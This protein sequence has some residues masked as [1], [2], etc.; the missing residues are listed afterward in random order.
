MRY[1]KVLI[2]GIIFLLSGCLKDDQA[3]EKKSL[4]NRVSLKTDISEFLHVVTPIPLSSESQDKKDPV[5]KEDIGVFEEPSPPLFPSPEVFSDEEIALPAPRAKEAQLKRYDKLEKRKS[6]SSRVQKNQNLRKE[7]KIQDKNY[8]DHLKG[9]EEDLSSFPI[10]GRRV[11]T[12]DRYIPV[13][14]ENAINSQLGGRFIAVVESHVFA[15]TGRGILL[16]KGTRIICTYESLSKEGDTRLG[17]QC[18]RAIRPDGASVLLTN[19][20]AADQMAR[21]GM[22]GRIDN[23]TWEKYGSSFIVAGISALSAAGANTSQTSIVNQSASNLSLNLGQITAGMLNANIDL[24][25]VMT[26]AAGSHLQI[27]PMTDIWLREP[28]EISD[29]HR[30]EDG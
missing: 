27:I 6:T 16:P 23:R 4:L 18:S 21:T 3:P 20:Y 5:E 25:P 19:A 17:A 15:H 10:E 9:I 30:E 1:Q 28:Q 12:A 8:Q 24:A 14:L 7:F 2:G 13:V 11:I 29:L 22:I 26:V